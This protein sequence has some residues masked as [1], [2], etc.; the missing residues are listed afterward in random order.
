MKNK[1]VISIVVIIVVITS[2][3]LGWKVFGFT[4]CSSPDTVTVSYVENEDKTVDITFHTSSSYLD[5]KGSV[6]KFKDGVL[7][8][9]ARYGMRW[10][11]SPVGSETITITI[12]GN[13]E[14]V[15]VSGSFKS[16]EIQ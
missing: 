16:K 15:I 14:K 9:G 6:Y 11:G 12:D 10:F 3:S 2:V 1:I 5:Y 4:F 8:V 7:T 13:I